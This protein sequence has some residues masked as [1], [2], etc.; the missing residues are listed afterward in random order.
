MLN[1]LVLMGDESCL[2]SMVAEISSS[3]KEIEPIE[4]VGLNFEDDD[5]AVFD[6]AVDKAWNALGALDAF[7]NC[8]LY[9]GNNQTRYSSVIWL[10][11]CLYAFLDYMISR[12]LSSW[13]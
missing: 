10:Q 6:A 8:Y 3:L 13:P 11:L 5:E 2:R 1:R 12:V 4:V 9:E 7:V